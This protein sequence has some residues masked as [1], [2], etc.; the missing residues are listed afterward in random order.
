MATADDFG[1]VK[2]YKFPAHEQKEMAHHKYYGHSSHVT[3]VSFS[4]DGRYVITTG[5][6]D[7]SIFQWKYV[8][9]NMPETTTRTA[10]HEETKD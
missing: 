4:N 5:G 3:N 8:S 9:A 7:K 1:T 10:V 6:E 2:L